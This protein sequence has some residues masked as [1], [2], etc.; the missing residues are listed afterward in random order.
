MKRYPGLEKTILPIQ[1]YTWK[2]FLQTP[3]CFPLGGFELKKKKEEEMKKIFE[4]LN[5]EFKTKSS[6][7]NGM[8]DMIKFD[9]GDKL[10]LVKNIFF[11]FIFFSFY[12]FIFIFIF[13]LI[14]FLFYFIFFILFLKLGMEIF[15]MELA[16]FFQGIR[17]F[18][19]QTIFQRNN[20]EPSINRFSEQMFHCV[21]QSFF[22]FG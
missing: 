20:H 6:K 21:S 10:P 16:L 3:R 7:N 19:G 14:F 2:I 15:E 11:Y 9:N 1:Y 13:I 4:N 22:I 8:I 17:R 5:F 12:F 18:I